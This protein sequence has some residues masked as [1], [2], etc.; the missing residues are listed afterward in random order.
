MRQVAL[1]TETTG[2]DPLKGHRLVEIGC[3][4][5]VNR[6]L[7]GRRFHTYINPEREVEKEAT[8]ITGLTYEFLR[9]KPKF[10]D[11]VKE[12]VEF[13]QVPRT[14]LI[15]HNA[16]FDLGFLNYELDL[17]NYHWHPV[18]NYLSIIDTLVLARRIHPGQRNSL[19]V[20]CSRYNVD[21]SHR[22][23]HG[24]LLDAELLAKVYLAM[25]AG[26]TSMAWG[27]ETSRLDMTEVKLSIQRVKRNLNVPLNIIRATQEECKTHDARMA[28][29]EAIHKKNA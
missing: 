1:D 20:L 2:L 21:N 16:P 5:I 15:I 29:I 9:D 25:T 17:L 8:A 11:I 14:E 12:F 13:L 22:E 7:T 24:A 6:R 19:D 3:L 18:E 26:Q 23:Y 4:E 10:S 27:N 28:F